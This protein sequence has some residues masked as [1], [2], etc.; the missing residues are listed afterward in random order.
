MI[1]SSE[2]H[3]IHFCVRT[4]HLYLWFSVYGV[5]STLTQ[6]PMTLVMLNENLSIR[7]MD[8]GLSFADM[9]D[10]FLSSL[11]IFVV[12]IY[13]VILKTIWDLWSHFSWLYK[14]FFF[15]L[16][17]IDLMLFKETLMF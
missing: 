6:S 4:S 13:W 12:G 8:T 5:V 7:F 16:G 3:S 14:I 9:H 10:K 17:S 1:R 15:R 11:V 2:E